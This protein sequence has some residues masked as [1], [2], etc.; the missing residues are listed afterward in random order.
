MMDYIYFWGGFFVWASAGMGIGDSLYKPKEP[1]APHGIVEKIFTVL[2]LV[3][4][5]ALLIWW[6]FF[7]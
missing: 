7:R 2:W 5:V 1:F 3:L 4:G 6:H